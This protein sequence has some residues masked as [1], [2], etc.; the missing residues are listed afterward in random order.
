VVD[1]NIERGTFGVTL[2]QVTAMDAWVERT[3]QQWGLSE[4]A[5]FYAR[6]CIAELAANLLEH[7]VAR[8]PDDQIVLRIGRFR[9]G[10]GVEFLDSRESFD[11]TIPQEASTASQNEGGR[12][13]VLLR[14]YA[15]DLTYI[16]GPNCNRT[17][18]KISAA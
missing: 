14:A 12:G 10:I 17:T 8:L 6:L 2:D 11:P 4:R 13:L 18:F 1:G 5:I 7:G 3:V 16:S 15:R 9:D